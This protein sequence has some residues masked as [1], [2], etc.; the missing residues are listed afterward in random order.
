MNELLEKY[1]PNLTAEQRHLFGQL[2]PLYEEWNA[3]I[4]VVSRKDMYEFYLHHVLHSMAIAKFIQFEKGTKVMDLGTGGGFPGIPLAILFPKTEFILVDSIQKKIMVVSEVAN[5]LGLKNVTAIRS[6]A[7]EANLKVDFV[8]SRAVAPLVDLWKW[9]SSY[10][11]PGGIHS[12]A[13]GLIALKGGDLQNEI[14]E[15][16]KK[17]VVHSLSEYFSESFFETKQ[18]IYVMR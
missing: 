15:L 7:E 13:N 12:H 5:S 8:V 18:L 14:K 2:K 16:K 1:F 11:K 9:S 17:C 10:I 3:K 4:N 6:R